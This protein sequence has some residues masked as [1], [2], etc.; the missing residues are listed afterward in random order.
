MLQN[1]A[2]ET[3]NRYERARR[4]REK[5]EHATN[6]G[7]RADFLAAERRWLALGSSYDLR[8]SPTVAGFDSCGGAGVATPSLLEQG[9]AFDPDDVTRLTT[10]YHAALYQLGLVDYEDGVTLLIAKLI[11]D[12]AARGERDPERLIAATIESL[13]R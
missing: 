7:F 2:A 3:I 13:A 6:D 11:V 1:L 8:S 5:A 4:A 10:A 9:I 12:L